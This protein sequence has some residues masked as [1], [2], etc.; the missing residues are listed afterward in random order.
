LQDSK[1][2]SAIKS[3]LCKQHAWHLH[4][5]SR[6][7]DWQ[8][9]QL[10]TAVDPLL[11]YAMPPCYYSIQW[12]PEVRLLASYQQTLHRDCRRVLPPFLQPPRCNG[13][14]KCNEAAAPSL[15]DSAAASA[16][17]ARATAPTTAAAEAGPAA[18]SAAAAAGGGAGK[19]TSMSDFGRLE[20][21]THKE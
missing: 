7:S 16:A 18:G 3:V 4:V 11:Y 5:S 2:Q 19:N 14:G 8:Q 12:S 10:Q 6:C 20:N 21:E 1:L 13:G 15:L 17:A 9:R